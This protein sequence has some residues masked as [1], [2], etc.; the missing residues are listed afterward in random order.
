MF[1]DEKKINFY[2]IVFFTKTFTNNVYFPSVTNIKTFST[3]VA[4]KTIKNLRCF[5][6]TIRSGWNIQMS[7]QLHS[8]FPL[9]F[10]YTYKNNLHFL[11]R[12]KQ[13]FTYNKSLKG[14]ALLETLVK[15]VGSQKIQFLKNLVLKKKNIYLVFKFCKRW[16]SLEK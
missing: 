9:D 15:Y 11:P 12:S 7:S 13:L 16:S 5:D 14:V 3:L 2:H 8:K 4:F 6:S 1:Y 10:G